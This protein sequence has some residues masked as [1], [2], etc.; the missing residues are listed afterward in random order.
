[1]KERSTDNPKFERKM[2]MDLHKTDSEFMERF[3]QFAFDEV[4]NE[5]G[6]QLPEHTRYLAILATLIGC[7]GWTLIKKCFPKH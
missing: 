4:V 7:G 5:K 2:K 6:Q 1:M 3:E